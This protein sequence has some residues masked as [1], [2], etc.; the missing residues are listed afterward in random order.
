MSIVPRRLRQVRNL[1]GRQLLFGRSWSRGRLEPSRR[2]VGRLGRRS[3]PPSPGGITGPGRGLPREVGVMPFFV[4]CSPLPT[5]I[6]A[7]FASF[8]LLALAPRFRTARLVARLPSGLDRAREAPRALRPGR[9]GP[10]PPHR[11][12]GAAPPPLGAIGTSLLSLVLVADAYR[13]G[14]TRRVRDRRRTHRP[15]LRLRPARLGPVALASR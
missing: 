7:L 4:A 3:R 8:A 11:R 2:R 12:R 6:A 5:P 9:P 13:G 1:H 10:S 14:G 15:S